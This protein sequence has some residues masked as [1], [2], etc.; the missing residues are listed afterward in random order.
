MAT[1]RRLCIAADIKK[2]STRKVPEQIQAQQ[3]LATVTRAACRA[4]GLPESIAQT[5]GDGVL[6][7]APAGIDETAVIPAFVHALTVALEQENRMLAESARIRLRLS[8][9]TGSISDGPTGFGG[10][11]IVEC[12]RLLDSAPVRTALDDH[13]NAHLA[14]IVSDH[15]YRDVIQHDF[16]SLR[17]AD[18]WPG[19]SVVKDFAADAWVAVSDRTGGPD[20][21]PSEPEPPEVTGEPSPPPAFTEADILCAAGDHDGAAEVLNRFLREQPGR[22]VPGALLRLGRVHN[23]RG[24]SR[25]ARHTWRYLLETHERSDACLELGRLEHRDGDSALARTYLLQ[26][27]RIA[28]REKEPLEPLVDALLELPP[29]D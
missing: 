26:G 23:L 12:F 3:S 24:D 8:L 28:R 17:S 1:Q 20:R 18:F 6:L 29:A 4:A 22:D 25:A 5:Q 11:A 7:L 13:P 9:T 10:A 2:W 21:P 15:L 16:G 27:L 14:L 19:R